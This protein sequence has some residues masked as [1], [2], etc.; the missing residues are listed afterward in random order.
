MTVKTI[1]G[2]V[3][4]GKIELRE[5]LDAADGTEVEVNVPVQTGQNRPITFG[6][7]AKPGGRKTTWE[8]FQEA[9]KI[10]EPKDL[11]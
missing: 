4:G 3:R 2:V 11:S 1:K 7:F 6:M 9:K 10:W 5:S 8:D